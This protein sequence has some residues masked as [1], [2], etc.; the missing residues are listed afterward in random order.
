MGEINL[1]FITNKYF[2]NLTAKTLTFIRKIYKSALSNVF[3]S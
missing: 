3:S 1:W 2:H